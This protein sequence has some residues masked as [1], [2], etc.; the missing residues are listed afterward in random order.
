MLP[1]G[2]RKLSDLLSA[3]SLFLAVLGVLFG[4]WYP[5]ISKALEVKV[6]QFKEDRV[7]PRGAVLSVYV[8]RAVPL[9][10][11]STIFSLVLVPD[12]YEITA[13]SLVAYRADLLS[14]LRNY[15]AVET[16]FCCVFLMSLFLTCYLIMMIVGLKDLLRRFDQENS[17]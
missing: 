11:S 17:T 12:V 6:P 14:A 3:A 10:I 13:S 9:L 2:I 15:G 4:L 16:L 7:A 5:E 1:K 8:G